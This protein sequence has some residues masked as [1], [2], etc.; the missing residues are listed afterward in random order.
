ME[1]GIIFVHRPETFMP[2]PHQKAIAA[3]KQGKVW[4]EVN[5]KAM[6]EYIDQLIAKLHRTKHKNEQ[7][8]E[9]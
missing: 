9:E 2:Y 5:R 7:S 6:V 3:V 1:H 8:T 4:V